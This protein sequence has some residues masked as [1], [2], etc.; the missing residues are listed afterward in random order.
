VGGV[1]GAVGAGLLVLAWLPTSA[2]G[3]EEKLVIGQVQ[4]V[5]LKKNV[6]VV[7]DPERERTVRL[8]VDA[9]TEV[10]RCRQGR[11]LAGLPVGTHVRVKYVDRPG[12]EAETLSILILP[13]RR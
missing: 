2:L 8:V 4:Q 9:E 6:L 11:S 13:G 7:Q 10:R 12:G 3:H 5:D 1:T